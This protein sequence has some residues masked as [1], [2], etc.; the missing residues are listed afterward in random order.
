MVLE[1]YF[2]SQLGPFYPDALEAFHHSPDFEEA[3]KRFER[4]NCLLNSDNIEYWKTLN[5]H[6]L[7]EFKYLYIM[8]EEWDLT[9]ASALLD[10][11][12]TANNNL[13][14]IILDISRISPASP[15]D[16]L[17]LERSIFNMIASLVQASHNCVDTVSVLFGPGEE[18]MEELTVFIIKERLKITPS[19]RRNTMVTGRGNLRVCVWLLTRRQPR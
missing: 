14:S 2:E 5:Q 17:Q 3:R 19:S 13:H 15:V 11:P 6:D 9:S 1:C 10:N 18:M 8:L 16:F 12:L 4:T 7:L